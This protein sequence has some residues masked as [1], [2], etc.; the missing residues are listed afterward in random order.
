MKNNNLFQSQYFRSFPGS[1]SKERDI[2]DDEPLSDLDEPEDIAKEWQIASTKL[3]K[4]DKREEYEREKNIQK[5][6]DD[7]RV[8]MKAMS[9]QGRAINRAMK[10]NPYP[11]I[12]SSL[13]Q[14]SCGIELKPIT[15]TENEIMNAEMEVMKMII[16]REQLLERLKLLFDTTEMTYSNILNDPENKQ[17]GA[18]KDTI[19]FSHNEF[20]VL[21]SSIQTASMKVIEAIR[22]YVLYYYYSIFYYINID[23]EGNGN[24]LIKL[25]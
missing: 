6:I 1:E 20:R 2:D 18:W 10:Y 13:T 24:N 22:V 21:F 25:D 8:T 9:E 4:G 16:L 11:D 12:K 19:R 14:L 17:C 5:Y 7:S 15:T 23:G 3:E